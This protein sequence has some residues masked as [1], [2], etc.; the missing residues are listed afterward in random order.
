[1]I[2]CRRRELYLMALPYFTTCMVTGIVKEGQQR[3]ALSWAVTGLPWTFRDARS[4]MDE[5]TH[6]M[7]MNVLY[8]TRPY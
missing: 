1:M 5:R 6:E 8:M 4:L 2:A 3:G 7:Q